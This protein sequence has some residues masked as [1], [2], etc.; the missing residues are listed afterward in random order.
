MRSKIFKEIANG[1]QFGM[2]ISTIVCTLNMIA[3]LFVDEQMRMVGMMGI[4]VLMV[5]MD[6]GCTFAWLCFDSA[7]TYAEMDEEEN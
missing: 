6:L 7:A 3:L 5:L 2:I 4:A 1:F